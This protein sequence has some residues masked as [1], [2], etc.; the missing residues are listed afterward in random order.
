MN[1]SQQFHCAKIMQNNFLK[2][3]II[4]EIMKDSILHIKFVF[5]VLTTAYYLTQCEGLS[6]WIN[7]T[8]KFLLNL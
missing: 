2:D 3:M 5:K 8:T 4:M 6:S 7:F 1:I